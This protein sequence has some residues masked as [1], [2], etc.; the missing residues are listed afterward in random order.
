MT[1]KLTT[2]FCLVFLCLTVNAQQMTGNSLPL[3]PYP[4]KVEIKDGQFDLSS[5]TQLIV[6]DNGLFWSEVS[7]LQSLLAPALGKGLSS[8]AGE[9]RLIVAYSDKIVGSEAYEIDITPSIMK[10]TACTPKGMFYAMQTI[11]QLLPHKI[12]SGRVIDEPL[13]LPALHISDKPAFEWRGTMIDVSRHFFSIEYLKKHIDRSALYK[14]NKLHLHLTDDQGWRIEIKKYPELTSKGAW[15]TYN[16]H[17]TI[18]MKLAKENLDFEIDKRYVIEKDGKEIYGGYY[19]QD[20]MKELIA[21]AASRHIEIIPEIDMPGHML[22]AINTYPYLT[23]AKIGWGESF[24]VPLCPCKDEVYTFVEGVL[25]EIIELFP[26][27]Y[28]HIGADE[29]EKTTW[30]ESDKCKALMARENLSNVDELQNYFVH[31]VQDYIESRGKKVI[32]WD[33]VLSSNINSNVN[34]MYWRRWVDAPQKA[35]KNGNFVIMSPT[36]PLYFDYTPNKS[37]LSSVYNMDVIYDNIPEGKE[38]H[39]RGAQANLWAE[40]IPSENRSE[41]MLFPRLTALAERVWKNQ[42]LFDSYSDR[43]LSHYPRMDELNINYRL[44]DLTG[45][46]LENVFVKEGY[47]KVDEPLAGMTVRYTTD[48]SLPTPTSTALTAPL[49]ITKPTQMKLALFSPGGAKSDIYTVNYREVKMPAATKIDTK[50]A[51]QG[52]RCQ[53]YNGSVKSTKEIKETADKEQIVANIVVPRD[54]RTSA[55]A[56]KF[57]GYIQ[58]PETGIYSFY[59]TCDDG[60]MLYI[61]NDLVVDND[62]LH[63]AIEKSGQAA[64]SKGAH[65]FRVDFVEGG[66]GFTLKLQYSFNGSKPQDIPDSWLIH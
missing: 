18:C 57:T 23:D 52:L 61:N 22:A 66:G 64:I 6:E 60:G 38:S 3:I 21:Y 10:I 65:P 37:S 20:Q 43:V 49:K 16:N 30:K 4:Q 1:K 58:V 44:P 15:R 41:F 33:E 11:R 50:T 42:D 54:F 59:L 51:K 8:V 63:P 46:T 48:G 29:V 17:D 39:I 27:Q 45:F 36:N 53:F 34:I 25:S 47:F 31:K 55:F 35:V 24:S 2:L 14:L 26:S 19:T 40:Q 13:C 32:A 5:R 7:Y 12:E 9:N 62:G 56:V 28:I